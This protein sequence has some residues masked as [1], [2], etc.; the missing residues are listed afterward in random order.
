MSSINN[1]IRRGC[2]SFQRNGNVAEKHR[3]TGLFTPTGVVATPSAA[4]G[5]L[6]TGTYSYRITARDA[7]GAE[8]VASPSVQPVVTGP[9]GSVALTWTPVANAK[10]YKVYGRAQVPELF[11]TTVTTASFTDTGALAAAG[12]MPTENRTTGVTA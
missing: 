6:A 11:I 7:D 2:K 5:T 10:D 8:T 3:G 4:G 9:T 12:A 1:A